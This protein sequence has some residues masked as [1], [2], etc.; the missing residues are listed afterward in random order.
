MVLRG[1]WPAVLSITL[2]TACS[3]LSAAEISADVFTHY[4][5]VTGVAAHETILTGFL[6]GG[7]TAELVAVHS[8]ASNN[9]RLKIF[10]FDGSNWNS[11]LDAPPIA[12]NSD[13]RCGEW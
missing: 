9:R 3:T 13:G 12:G 6:R 4:E 8:D 5:I 10:G 1:F 2:T 11:L 7:N